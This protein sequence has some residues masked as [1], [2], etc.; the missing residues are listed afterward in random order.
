MKTRIPMVVGSAVMVVCVFAFVNAQPGDPP[1]K[2]RAN[3]SAQDIL[4]HLQRLAPAERMRF[5]PPMERTLVAATQ[6][7]VTQSTVERGTLQAV[8]SSTIFC[9]VKATG[10]GSTVAATIRWV[11][12]DG[13]W[14]KKGDVLIDFDNSGHTEHVKG[15]K[16][17]VAQAEA[18]F[19][20]ATEHLAGIQRENDID[21]RL[22]EVDVR[23]ADLERKQYKGDDAFQKDILA[24]KVERQSLLLDRLKATARAKVGQAQAERDATKA[25]L[26]HEIAGLR[27][28]ER[29]SAKFIVHAPHDGFV[30]HYVPEQARFGSGSQ[31]SIV[32]QGEP[33]REGQKLL[34]VADLKQM[35]VV[36]RIHE[37]LISKVRVGQKASVRV[38]AFPGKVDTGKVTDIASVADQTGFFS[39]DVKVYQVVIAIDGENKTLKPGMSATVEVTLGE[40]AD[41]VRLPT[42]AILGVGGDRFCYI[43]MGNELHI[44]RAKFGLADANH[45]EVIDGVKQGEQALANPRAVADALSERLATGEKPKKGKLK[46]TQIEIRSVKPQDAGEKRTFVNTYGL[47]HKDRDRIEALLDVVDLVPV[48]RFQH[49]IRRQDRLHNGQVIATTPAYA[50]LRSLRMTEGRFLV[51]ADGD[52]D[53]RNVAV[54]GAAAAERL[55]P[56]EAPLGQ[57]VIL[58]GNSYTVVGVLTTIDATD[59]EALNT[60]HGVFIPLRTCQQRFGQRI[61]TRQSGQR[62]A[63][64]IE[65]NE[66]FV[67]VRDASRTQATADMIAALLEKSHAKRDWAMRVGP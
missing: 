10:K 59:M 66:I 30:V 34:L 3:P 38:D 67:T 32:A 25:M 14:V 49:E 6:G 18:R 53:L 60:N 61:Y 39:T 45:I 65:L 62:I 11:I 15:V 51:D 24:L 63:E 40:K 26:D 5:L 28:V 31:Q 20:K 44:R 42:T 43:A 21:I 58:N 54:L 33:V 37:A 2:L 52:D 4:D 7:A 16:N 46:P 55:V 12:D 19:A 22:A 50:N 29:D 35:A 27:E 41:C 47:L 1:K 56:N 8:K 17:V 48:R 57:S 64:E 36:T 13:S 23:L 9:N